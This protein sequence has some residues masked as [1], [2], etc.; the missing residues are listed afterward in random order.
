MPSNQLLYKNRWIAFVHIT[1]HIEHSSVSGVAFHSPK[2]CLYSLIYAKTENWI[3]M[4]SREMQNR[5]WKAAEWMCRRNGCVFFFQVSIEKHW[6]HNRMRLY[7]VHFLTINIRNELWNRQFRIFNGSILNDIFFFA[8]FNCS[9]N[10][11]ATFGFRL[12]R[13]SPT[14]KWNGL[15]AWCININFV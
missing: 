9:L 12:K 14:K 5:N 6:T 7:I 15:T 1:K 10:G 4:R 11:L 3:A 2:M 13:I 8:S